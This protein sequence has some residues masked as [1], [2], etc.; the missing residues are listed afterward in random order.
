MCVAVT[1][2]G[3]TKKDVELPSPLPDIL[4]RTCGDAAL[5]HMR[6]NSA[7]QWTQT[8]NAR[9]CSVLFGHVVRLRCCGEFR[10]YARLGSL[11]IACHPRGTALWIIPAQRAPAVA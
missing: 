3:F 4:I 1:V 6:L 9:R 10:H 7:A 8:P 11:S 2:L 5:I